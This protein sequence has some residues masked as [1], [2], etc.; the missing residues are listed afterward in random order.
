MAECAANAW[1]TFADHDALAVALSACLVDDFNA[2]V[3]ARG[4]A[5]FGASGGSTPKPVYQALTHSDVS[6]PL[7]SVLVVD[8]RAVPIGHECS[9]QR[10][11]ADVLLPER[12][13]VNL[14]G[15]W[16]DAP[17]LDAMAAIAADRVRALD[18]P[19]DVVVLGMGEDGHF[20]SCFPTATRFA[21]AIAA[22]GD[23]LVLPIAPMPADVHPA[24]ERL[25]LTWAYIRRARR[26][27]LAITGARKRAVL[28]QAMRDEDPAQLPIAALF[29][30]GMPAIDIYWSP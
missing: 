28:L 2:A 7:L 8:E 10:M 4:R 22:E 17:T 1:H 16:S 15:L 25:T 30:A 5:I 18:A 24:I 14:I 26:I 23:A 12:S 11:I 20:A 19:M 6:W 9:N 27:V 13:E 3:A 29:K 21:D